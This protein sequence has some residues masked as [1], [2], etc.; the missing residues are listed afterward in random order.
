M[1][2][3]HTVGSAPTQVSPSIT[4]IDC[5]WEQYAAFARQEFSTPGPEDELSEAEWAAFQYDPLDDP[6]RWAALCE[7]H[8]SGGLVA[9]RTR[10]RN[11]E[12]EAQAQEPRQEHVAGSKTAPSIEFYKALFVNTT[13]PL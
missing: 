12:A 9:L 8:A 5:P 3:E 10:L 4:T 2:S 7:W 6:E 11:V 1:Q 13:G